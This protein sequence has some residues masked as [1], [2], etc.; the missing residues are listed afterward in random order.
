MS[1]LASSRRPG[2][3]AFSPG[4]ATLVEGQSLCLAKPLN[5]PNPAWQIAALE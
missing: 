1:G 2:L 5:Y 3:T 4:E